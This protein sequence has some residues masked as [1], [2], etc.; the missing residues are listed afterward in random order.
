MLS[1]SGPQIAALQFGNGA[2]AEA[3][4]FNFKGEGNTSDPY[5]LAIEAL[6]DA[7][8]NMA[9]IDRNDIKKA[10][11]AIFYGQSAGAFLGAPM[12]GAEKVQDMIKSA[13]I[14]EEAARKFVDVVE[15]TFGKG[16]QGIRSAIRIARSK[17]V[18]DADLTYTMQDGFQ[19][20]GAYRTS[21]DLKG[22][23]VNVYENGEFIKA[24]DTTIEVDGKKVQFKKVAVETNI[25]DAD[26][27][28]RTAFVNYVQANDAEMA[29]HVV[30]NLKKHNAQTIIS[31]HDCFRVSINDMMDG[32][33]IEAIKE[34][35]TEMF[36]DAS[37]TDVLFN[38]GE[39]LK[40]INPTFRTQASRKAVDGT[41][42]YTKVAGVE[43]ADL[44]NSL[45]TEDGAYFFTK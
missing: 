22:Q 11:M 10:F 19:V 24:S 40:A 12:K 32:K 9:S 35:Y 31:V 14:P 34:A 2:M 15:A 1:V 21:L 28:L 38:F 4:G 30:R 37:E 33:L 27:N 23:R 45:G 25:I 26:S 3:C 41:P 44:I 39:G 6:K 8:F 7:G 13:M 5:Q 42:F 36:V 16:V 43:I 29:R 18:Q 17:G 20:V